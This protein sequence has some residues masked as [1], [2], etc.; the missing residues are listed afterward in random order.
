MQSL[1]ALVTAITLSMHPYSV[2]SKPKKGAAKQKPC[3]CVLEDWRCRELNRELCP[4]QAPK[5]EPKQ[6]EA[7]KPKPTTD[8]EYREAVGEL[9]SKARVGPAE[10]YAAWN[11]RMR[12]LN[13][14]SYTMWGLFS[15]SM[16]IGFGTGVAIF[17]CNHD[18]D[19]DDCDRVTPGVVATNIVAD[20]AAVPF[21]ITAIV[22]TVR[23][24]RHKRMSE[25]ERAN[26]R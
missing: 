25:V 1:V 6:E 17:A 7:P 4:V 5:Q 14:R 8:R 9:R 15:A 2:L 26:Y 22:L 13:I 21:L 20:I 10:G 18:G 24:N 11:Q 19:V 12:E 3:P 16:I 23:C